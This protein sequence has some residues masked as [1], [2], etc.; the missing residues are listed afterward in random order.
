VQSAIENP[1]AAPQPRLSGQVL[2]VVEGGMTE[3]I[4]AEPIIRSLAEQSHGQCFLTVC[5]KHADLYA[6]HPAVKCVIYDEE[7]AKSQGFGTILRLSAPTEFMP[8]DRQVQNY[9]G[10]MKITLTQK[11]PKI[12]LAGYDLIRAQRFG[13]CGLKKPRI[14]AAV[15]QMLSPAQKDAW[16]RFCE[17]LQCHSDC[18]VVLLGETKIDLPASKNLS[19][20]LTAREAA[21]VLSQCDILATTEERYAA[22]ALGV[23]IDAIV[24]GS[25]EA[26]AGKDEFSGIIRIHDFS[27]ELIL[28]AMRQRSTPVP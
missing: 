27:P 4:C 24:I 26:A 28:S 5:Q 23:G 18:S 7:E 2:I 10:Q 14:A 15:N 11:R 12:T 19:G 6:G 17:S 9:A 1:D 22:L 25:A 13:V 3:A 20:K 21:A 16:Q 8:F